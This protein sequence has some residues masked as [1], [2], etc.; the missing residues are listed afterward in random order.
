M[1][2]EREREI[3]CEKGRKLLRSRARKNVPMF[4]CF[5]R[6]MI[7][8]SFMMWYQ[9]EKLEY[10]EIR[11][12]TRHPGAIGQLGRCGDRWSCCRW[13]CCL[14]RLQGAIG[15]LGRLEEWWPC[16]RLRSSWRSSWC[17]SCW[18]SSWRWRFNWGGW[19]WCYCLWR[20]IPSRVC[21]RWSWVRRRSF[22]P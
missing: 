9:E 11:L 3:E 8:T 4:I 10:W 15:Q 2:R 13:W 5:P 12:R 7:F 1:K 19:S 22:G 14:L 18:R 16:W 17:R 6:F 21:L 20:R